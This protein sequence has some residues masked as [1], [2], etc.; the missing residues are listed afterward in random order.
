MMFEE[1]TMKENQVNGDDDRFGGK[2]TDSVDKENEKTKVRISTPSENGP[3]VTLE[4]FI[5][6]QDPAISQDLV[7][8]AHAKYVRNYWDSFYHQFADINNNKQWFRE[9]FSEEGEMA[10]IALQAQLMVLRHTRFW[11]LW[12]TRGALKNPS[13][14]DV[15]NLALK[16]NGQGLVLQKDV[17]EN[18]FV[19]ACLE[20]RGR[21]HLIES[22]IPLRASELR[23]KLASQI[24]LLDIHTLFPVL[25]SSTIY[26]L[27]VRHYSSEFEEKCSALYS[28]VSEKERV[29]V[30]SVGDN[31]LK[32]SKVKLGDESSW[33][34]TLEFALE[35]YGKIN[36]HL[37]VSDPE[38]QELLNSF[39]AN[40]QIICLANYFHYVL[41]MNLFKG[42]HC[43]NFQQFFNE[44]GDILIVEVGAKDAEELSF[45]TE[46]ITKLEVL[47]QHLSG[48]GGLMSVQERARAKVLKSYAK[49]SEGVFACEFCQKC[50]TT[51]E[52]V[53][54]HLSLKH[55]SNI[56]L[57]INR[58]SAK[59]ES[60]AVASDPFNKVFS[61][62]ESV[63]LHYQPLSR[64]S[65]FSGQSRRHRNESG[66]EDRRR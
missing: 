43:A 42:V 21:S 57:F 12:K 41:N 65:E 13:T 17:L 11:E 62:I 10:K 51:Q 58:Y 19:S 64:D 1:E 5:H 34:Q 15:T 16:T 6:H 59:H 4:E 44:S 49:V 32:V 56:E 55:E 20:L 40:E 63:R 9:R 60:E 47:L 45:Q 48:D 7:E 3:F 52:Y 35:S 53:V 27:L 25:T 31:F 26:K 18:E 23:E 61:R 22:K 46:T 50:F 29:K 28:D 36:A 30:H 2:E 24:T 8:Q 38:S 14:N 66:R 54:N 33:K 37:K 39:T